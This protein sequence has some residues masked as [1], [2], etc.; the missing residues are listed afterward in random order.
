M[1]D[2]SSKVC[3]ACSVDAPKATLRETDDFLKVHSNWA[4]SDE[5]NFPQ[6]VREFKFKNF[7]QAQ[8]FTN[9]VGVLAE[10]EGHHPSI[11]LEYGKVTVKWWSHKIKALHVN[12]FILSAKTED[13]YNSIDK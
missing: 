5:V 11:L 8:K 10:S 6:L 7:V 9:A 3:E 12:D 2:Y 4:L 1:V 13:L